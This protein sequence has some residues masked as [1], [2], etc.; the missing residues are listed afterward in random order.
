[1]R[2]LRAG[3][4]G[5]HI[6]RTRLP[7]ALGI[8]CDA[9]GW[10][11]EF[12]LIDTAD[13]ADFDLFATLDQMRSD[14]WTGVTITHPF[15]ADAAD[16][17]GR[18]MHADARHLGAANTLVFGDDI[19]GYNTDFTGF[20]SAF[21][22]LEN[23][24]GRTVMIGAGGVARAIAPALIQLGATDLAISDADPHRAKALADRI[25]PPARAITGPARAIADADGLVNAT[26]LGM[27]E[28]PGSAFDLAKI[29]PQSWAFD[30]VYTPVWT[31][32]LTDARS[33]GLKT[34][35]GFDLFRAMAVR[36]F[37]AYTGIMVDDPDVAHALDQLQPKETV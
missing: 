22:A 24:P 12:D 27:V 32:F 36:S 2:I 19:C 15:K 8:L 20:L 3:L 35:T 4:I 9:A 14:G 33:K 1:M 23:T 26:P 28:Y 25:G 16:Y 5:Q 18:A 34:L 13:I 6:S 10:T 30:A 11:L 29:G 31:P 21:K 17:A 37:Q 7:A